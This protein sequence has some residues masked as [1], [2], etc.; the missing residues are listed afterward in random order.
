[1]LRVKKGKITILSVFFFNSQNGKAI[2]LYIAVS[3][4]NNSSNRYLAGSQS[5]LECESV[6]CF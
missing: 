2:L 4:V 5:F 6:E 3:Q 1:M